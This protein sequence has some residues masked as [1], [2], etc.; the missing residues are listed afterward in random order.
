MT[1][2][3]VALHADW[4]NLVHEAGPFLTLPVLRRVFPSGLDRTPADLRAEFRD[5]VADEDRPGFVEWVVRDLLEYGDTVNTGQT[6]PEDLVATPH[7]GVV[8]RPQLAV[9]K[10]KTARLLVHI[11]PRNTDITAPLADPRWA[12]SPVDRMATHLRSVHGPEL[13]LLSDG[14]RFTLVWAPKTGAVGR[15]TWHA[16]I[17]T[18]HG[19]RTLLDA[20]TSIL[21]AKRLFGVAEEDTLEALLHKSQAAQAEVTKQLGVQVRKSVELLVGAISRANRERGSELLR[22]IDPHHVYEAACT[23]MMRLVFLLFAEERNLLPLGDPLYDRSYAV[24]TLRSILREDADREGNVQLLEHRVTSW[25][26][27]LALFRAVYAGLTHDELRIPAYGGRLFDPDRYAFLEGRA[28]GTSWRDTDAEP[29]PVDDHAVLEIL[30]ALQVLEMREGGVTEAR[31]LSFRTLDVEQIG[32]VYEG[33]LD[34]GC[35]REDEVV[36]GLVGVKGIEPEMHLA[37]L[38]AEAKK[39]RESLVVFLQERTSRTERQIT[40]AL[41]TVPDEDRA[42]VVLAACEGDQGLAARLDPFAY[43]LRDDLRGLPIVFLPGSYYVTDVSHRRDTGT[44]YTTRELADEIAHYTLEPLV[45]DPGPAQGADEKDWKLKSA[46]DILSLRIC[47]P[48]VGSGAILV[49]AGRYLAERLIEGWIADGRVKATD[50]EV[51]EDIRTD[52]MRAVA[53][54]CLYGVDRDP[55]AVEM[56]KLSLWLVTMARER[57]FSF[58]DHALQSGDSLLGITD[59]RQV[60]NLH[61]DPER[62]ADLHRNLFD[63]TASLQPLVKEAVELRRLIESTPVVTVADA[64]EKARLL[65]EAEGKVASVRIVAD[66]VV[67]AALSRADNNKSDFVSRLLVIAPEVPAAL[68]QDV[69]L[70]E[71]RERMSRLAAKADAW[72]NEGRP[73]GAPARRCLH[74][75]L[76]FPEVFLDRTQ[77]GFDAMVGNP[78][79]LGG[80]RITGSMGTDFREHLVRWIAH[81]ARGSADLVSYFF[82]RASTVARRFGFLA[83]NTISQGDTREV[84]IDQLLERGW[85]VTRAVKSEPWPGE[86]SNEVSKLWLTRDAWHGQFVLDGSATSG[87]TTSLDPVSRVAG[88]P[89]P[90]PALRALCQHGSEP[91]GEGFI[92]SAAEAQRLLSHDPRNRH[93]VL[94]YLTGADL[95]S[96]PDQ[97]ATRWAIFFWDWPLERASQ[98]PVCLQH[99]ETHVKPKREKNRDPNRRTFW[100]RF[101][102]TAMELYESISKLD[103]ALAISLV[104]KTLQP[105]FVNPRQVFANKLGVFLYDDDFH[106][107][108]LSSGTHWCWTIRW[109]ST[110]RKDPNYSP[111]DCFET[112]PQCDFSEE[113]AAA[114]KALDEDRRELMLAREEGLTKTYNRVHDPDEHAQDVAHLRELHVALDHAVARAYGWDDLTLDHDFH[115]TSQGARYSVKPAARTEILD[116]LLELNQLRHQEEMERLPQDATHVSRK[117]A[118][119]LHLLSQPKHS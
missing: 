15:A 19:E 5:R 67:G 78:P 99:V 47:D 91:S 52:A 44:Q 98:Y 32:H 36:V 11:Y 16:S 69:P 115:P 49:A 105:V 83:V 79:F 51:P 74:W 56:A 66:V 80:Q 116:R 86:A 103:R 4:L 7:P 84:G 76:S 53:E 17:L 40:K 1:R 85:T 45:Y 110:L 109:S 12:A 25:P 50:G 21:G 42:R 14:E 88:R 20:F 27:L 55:M 59:L 61:M 81:G 108:L 34:H 23:V 24:S 97:S 90:L 62:G 46:D 89:T 37:E 107:G 30:S 104:S 101:G 94:P 72:L 64:E 2:T 58:L 73:E 28:M 68:D 93:V 3:V 102:R 54:R 41:D 70:D 106:F 39:G 35:K 75:P 96:S 10:A 118:S 112:F 114:G 13:G 65:R 111:S 43:L 87:I 33:L 100:W 31:R 77:P 117:V 29:I 95:N 71:R 9:V 22:G 60:E 48:A 113:I 57:P 6:I 63:Y 38:E 26:R 92:L 8:L 18:E 82:L 119:Q